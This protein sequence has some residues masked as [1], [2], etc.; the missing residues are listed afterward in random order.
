MFL[1]L[2][3]MLFVISIISGVVLYGPIM[4]NFDFGMVRKDKSKRL[5]W[6]D[7]HNLLGI[8]VMAW[9]LVVGITGVINAM[10]DVIVGLWQQG[11]LAEM[12]APYKMKNLIQAH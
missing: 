8:V 12:T 1:G 11:Q 5:K 9:M 3:G 4:K 7:T 6:L 10:S 2:M